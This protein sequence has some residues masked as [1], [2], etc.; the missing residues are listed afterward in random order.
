MEQLIFIFL[1]AM[2]LTEGPTFS[3]QRNKA[4]GD[5]HLQR[6]ME[7]FGTITID[8]QDKKIIIKH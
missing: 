6:A 4:V 5:Y 7:S 2:L 3:A 1:S 8:N